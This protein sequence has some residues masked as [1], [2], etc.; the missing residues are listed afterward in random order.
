[1]QLRRKRRLGK[2]KNE[3]N[4]KNR[5]KIVIAGVCAC[6]II[7]CAAGGFFI[8][9]FMD[10]SDTVVPVSSVSDIMGIG[11]GSG[12]QNRFAGVIESQKSWTAKKDS[13]RDIKK[14]YVKEGDEVKV[15]D[16]LFKYD[17]SSMEDELAQAKI[18]LQQYDVDKAELESQIKEL[19]AE[20][21][22]AAAT[23]KLSYTLQIQSA[24]NDIKK[25]EYEKKQKQQEIEKLE[26][27]M[28]DTTVVSE[29]DGIVTKVNS[30]TNSS[31]DDSDDASESTGDSSS[32]SGDAL[33]T[34]TGVGNYRVKCKINEQNYSDISEGDS[35]LVYS[36]VDDDAVWSGTVASVDA[37]NSTEES[38]D[39]TENEDYSSDE[40]E[41][42]TSSTSYTFYVN[43]DSSDNLLLG[44]HV[45]VEVDNGQA[46]T[47]DGIWLDES[48]ICDADSD[49]YVWAATSKGRLTKQYIIL[50]TYDEEMYRY[51]VVSGLSED[52]LIAFPDDSYTEGMKTEESS[53]EY[54]DSYSDDGT[55]D[56]DVYSEDEEWDDGELDESDDMMDSESLED[57]AL[58]GLDLNTD[59][60]E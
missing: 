10:S 4:R 30:Y 44:Q 37:G 8:Y 47:K 13:S 52:D 20:K 58:D 21:K 33:I 14:V 7:A 50:G 51:E 22:T 28:D 48:Y 42:L 18:E 55:T 40:D 25:N 34:I 31:E 54:D 45:Y 35:M 57:S 26:S 53:Y 32:D 43:L 9:R 24:Q 12:S 5:K 6:V 59:E 39:G 36:R 46:S 1:M 29:L 38:A 27:S 11:S 56:D 23:D 41:S 19:E 17:Q 15:G 60:G 3:K 49:A 16:K 2:R